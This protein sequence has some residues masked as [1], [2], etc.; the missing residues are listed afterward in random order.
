MRLRNAPLVHVLAQVAF[1]PLPKWEERVGDLQEI[2]VEAGFPR[3]RPVETRELAFSL[4]AAGPA[5]LQPAVNRHWD[6]ADKAQTSAFILSATSLVLHTSAY[7]SRGPFLTT[8]ERGLDALAATMKVSVVDRIG[9]R[10]VDFVQPPLGENIGLYVHPGLLGFPFREKPEL[11]ARRGA[12][13]TQSVAFTPVGT[14]AIRSAVVQPGQYLPPDLAPES[15][16]R[17]GNVDTDRGGLVVDFDHFSVFTGP[18]AVSLDFD[19]KNIIKH[20]HNLHATLRHAFDAIAT[21]YAL[22][23]WGPWEAVD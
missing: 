4:S 19:P 6:F 5:D 18:E 22:K 15:L 10:Y 16:R 2:M 7:H 20:L 23:Q 13:A 21:P 8:L 3:G 12:F 14:L 1:P 9:L 11:E 17:P